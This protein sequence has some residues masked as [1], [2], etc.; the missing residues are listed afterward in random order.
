M[1]AYKSSLN[2]NPRNLRHLPSKLLASKPEQ[3]SSR[4][5]ADITD[6]EDPDVQMW[7]DIIHDDREKTERPEQIDCHGYLV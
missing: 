6:D 1:N 4:N 5:H 3:V 7:S 2:E